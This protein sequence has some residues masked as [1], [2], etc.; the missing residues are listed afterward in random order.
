MTNSTFA[1]ATWDKNLAAAD[2]LDK[3][4]F[5]ADDTYYA[6]LAAAEATH[7]AAALAAREAYYAASIAADEQHRYRTICGS[8]C[9]VN[10]QH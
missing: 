1:A 5:D 8:A 2:A 4:L 3:A 7:D 9:S 6:A 10:G